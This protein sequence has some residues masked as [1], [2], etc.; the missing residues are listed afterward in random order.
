VNQACAA[1]GYGFTVED[2]LIGRDS[3]VPSMTNAVAE[4]HPIG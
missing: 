1:E 2:A 3:A 4:A